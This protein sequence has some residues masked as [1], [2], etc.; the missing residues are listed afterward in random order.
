M[1]IPRRSQFNPK[2]RGAESAGIGASWEDVAWSTAVAGSENELE[3][4][5]LPLDLFEWNLCLKFDPLFCRD[6][7][8]A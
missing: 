2:K 4:A 1:A 3:R 5:L 6:R 7:P 8:Q